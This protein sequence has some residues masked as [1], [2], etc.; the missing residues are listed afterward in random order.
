[1]QERQQA[2]I[3]N[4]AAAVQD[5]RSPPKKG[6]FT[7]ITGA[8]ERDVFQQLDPHLIGGSRSFG[9]LVHQH[10]VGVVAVQGVDR[11][12]GQILRRVH[13]RLARLK[14]RG[15]HAQ[16]RVMIEVI[17]FLYLFFLIAFSI[18][19]SISSP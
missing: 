6:Y 17:S 3:K 14:T 15:P 13:C 10:K 19:G 11:A 1:M 8:L 2:T 18:Y 5:S 12:V 16:R 4:S 9:I 7:S